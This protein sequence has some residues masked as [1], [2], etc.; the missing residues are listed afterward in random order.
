MRGTTWDFLALVVLPVAAA[1]WLGL[2]VRSLINTHRELWSLWLF[3]LAATTALWVYLVL[4]VV[5]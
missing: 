2:L 5:P 1:C 3:L 4:E